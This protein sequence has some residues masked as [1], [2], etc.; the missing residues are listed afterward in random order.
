MLNRTSIAILAAAAIFSAASA[1]QAGGS[2]NDADQP[3]DPHM[4]RLGH[5]YAYV[6]RYRFERRSFRGTYAYVPRSRF[7]RRWYDE[8]GIGRAATGQPHS[9][10]PPEGG[11]GK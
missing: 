5:A 1:A 9:S 10:K 8:Q 11:S 7:E 2:K 4:S 6:P 3:G